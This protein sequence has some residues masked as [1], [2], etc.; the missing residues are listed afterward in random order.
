MYRLTPLVGNV[1]DVPFNISIS[2]A[3]IRLNKF[4]GPSI[5]G[6]TFFIVSINAGKSLERNEST[7]SHA[8]LAYTI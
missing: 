2:S 8:S 3:V 6:T 7:T 1:I 5:I 4:F